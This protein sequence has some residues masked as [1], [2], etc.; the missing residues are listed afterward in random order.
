[1]NGERIFCAVLIVLVALF[2][3]IGTVAIILGV[4]GNPAPYGVG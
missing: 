3:I 1:M 2:A 4:T